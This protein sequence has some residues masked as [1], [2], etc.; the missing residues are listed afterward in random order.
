[1]HARRIAILA[2]V[3]LSW[4]VTHAR[5]Q[6]FITPFVGFNAG[7][8]STNCASL[9]NCEEKRLNWG[10]SVGKINGVFGLEEELAY[11][12]DFFGKT[13]GG[14]NAVLTLM[15]NLLAV[16]PA[17]PVQPYVLVGLGLMRSHAKL[18]ATSL[19]L[20]RNTLGYDIGGGLNI[21]FGHSIGVRGDVR[22]LKTLQDV[23]LGVFNSDKL[24]FWRGSAGVTFR[25]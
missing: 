5:A 23:T 4:T 6:G 15:S 12:R 24:E 10:V 1:M 8:D 16:V 21:F 14:D 13:P 22:R 19:T 7:G 2:F 17:G 11:A 3:L 20:A 25:F 9:T 18:D